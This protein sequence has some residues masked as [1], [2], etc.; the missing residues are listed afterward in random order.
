MALYLAK[1]EKNI[2]TNKI[3]GNDRL[4]YFKLLDAPEVEENGEK[5]IDWK[6]A[7]ELMVFWKSKSGKGY[8]GKYSTP[9][10]TPKETPKTEI[11]KVEYPTDEIDPNDIPF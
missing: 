3:N 9:R 11:K 7:K 5:K 1:Q 6:N 2:E 10:E 4:P 8:N